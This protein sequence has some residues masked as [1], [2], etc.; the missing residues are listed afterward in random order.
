[1]DKLLDFKCM[2]QQAKLLFLPNAWDVLSAV[3]L[4]QAGFKAIGTT[5]YGVAHAMGFE[6]GQNIEFDDLLTLVKKILSAV[7]VPVTVDIES[8]YSDDIR[9]ITENVLKLANLGACGI[10]LED[11]LKDDEPGLNDKEKQCALF[12]SIRGS[13]N[14]NGYRDFFIN[15]RIDTYL[16]KQNPFNETIERALDYI[17]SGADGI[18]VPGLSEFDEI[19]SVVNAISAPLNVMSLPGLTDSNQ[20]N[21]LGVK[22]FSIGYAFSDATISFIEATA[23][24]LYANK[25]TKDLYTDQNISISFRK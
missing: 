23:H 9:L 14:S 15:A 6:D 7:K 17:N 3:V 21:K 20:L 1:M 4:E 10:N 16:Q 2:H 13:L 5:S 24:S 19:E 22:R 12:K 8:G 18:F 25:E 11:S